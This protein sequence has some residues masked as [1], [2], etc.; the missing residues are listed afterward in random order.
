[1]A[2]ARQQASAQTAAAIMSVAR[3]EV[4]DKGGAG[5]SMRAV[6]RKV[7]LVSSAVYRHYPSRDALLTAMIIDS[8]RD[9]DKTLCGVEPAVGAAGWRDLA[10]SFRSWARQHPAQFH[11]IYGTPISGYAAPI[12][13][14]PAAGA[15]ALHFLNVGA[16][17]PVDVFATPALILQMQHP[18]AQVPGSE[19]SGV[20]AVLAELAALVGCV[21]LE[22]AGHFAGTADPAGDLYAAMLNRQITTLALPDSP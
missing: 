22:L 7:G 20:A 2:T 15:V 4:A 1:M 18:S 3:E 9:L 14:I 5:L 17:F 21:S 11:L 12:E 13:T 6:A 8:Y 10:R 16:R 19:P